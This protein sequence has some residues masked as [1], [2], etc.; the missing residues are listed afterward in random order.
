MS[1]FKQYSCEDCD[2][3]YDESL[4]DPDSGFAPGTLWQD[5]PDD[6]FCPECGSPKSEF[7]VLEP[8]C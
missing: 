7:R 3:I 5:I 4:G 1:E 6:W 2:F 8:V